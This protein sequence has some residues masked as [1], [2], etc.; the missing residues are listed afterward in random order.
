MLETF[1][2]AIALAVLGFAFGTTLKVSDLLQ[3]HGYRWFGRR[4]DVPAGIVCSG[5]ALGLLG[6]SPA[7]HVVFWVAVVVS[8][9]L[10]G[11]IDGVNHGILA[12][13][14]LAFSMFRISLRENLA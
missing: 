14:M 3:E 4:G 7:A 2:R 13:T 9:I 12:I 1:A 11:R 6:L 5:F 8:W 10:R